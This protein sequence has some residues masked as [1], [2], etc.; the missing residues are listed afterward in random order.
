MPTAVVT[1]P[2]VIANDTTGILNVTSDYQSGDSFPIGTT[3]VTYWV[4][5]DNGN[6]RASC[7]FHVNV[8][9]RY[10][11]DTSIAYHV[12]NVTLSLATD[13]L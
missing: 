11:R 3:I 9:G 7:S 1:W 8:V 6:I 5:D 2:D 12:I 10:L 13:S 4:E